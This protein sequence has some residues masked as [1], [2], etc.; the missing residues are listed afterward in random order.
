MILSTATVQGI[1]KNKA[2]RPL[3]DVDLG[4]I[5]CKSITGDI[6]CSSDAVLLGLCDIENATVLIK[7]LPDYLATSEA[8]TVLTRFIKKQNGLDLIGKINLINTGQNN[9]LL[10]Y[11]LPKGEMLSVL[12]E[13]RAL[14]F[15]SVQVVSFLILLRSILQQQERVEIKHG[16]IEI[17]SIYISETGS[18]YLL[19]SVVVAVKHELIKNKTLPFQMIPNGNA[20]TASPEICF[21][22]KITAQDSAFN[23]AMLV[24]ELVSGYHPYNGK[25]SIEALIAKESP[26]CGGDLTHYQREAL[27]QGVSLQVNRR[28]QSVNELIEK[29]I[30]PATNEPLHPQL[31]IIKQSIVF[32]QQNQRKIT[33]Q[34]KTKQVKNK[35]SP[36]VD[37][38]LSSRQYKKNKKDKLL[39]EKQSK[40]Q[41][42]Q[43]KQADLEGIKL[44]NPYLKIETT[45]ISLNPPTQEEKTIIQTE[46]YKLIYQ[47]DGNK[48]WLLIPI[49]LG[50]TLGAMLMAFLLASFHF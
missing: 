18:L 26:K 6:F 8:T 1:D 36:P 27:L 3:D 39:K 12:V 45:K 32:K 35:P 9:S 5:L 25:N 40:F 24:C 30:A 20:I 11:N 21:G 31:K 17:N 46:N 13:R 14:L 44:E 19:D 33:K 47:N 41:P 4:E 22:R 43:E 29:F 15:D 49:I 37:S 28:L 38:K 48:Y 2:L 16:M 34:K 42:L 50:S 23:L 10:V 7:K